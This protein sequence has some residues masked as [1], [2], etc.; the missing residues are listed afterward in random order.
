MFWIGLMIGLFAGVAMG[1]FTAGLCAMA[2]KRDPQLEPVG[3]EACYAGSENPC[4]D[5]CLSTTL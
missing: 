2:A 3:A 1:L 4:R 5:E